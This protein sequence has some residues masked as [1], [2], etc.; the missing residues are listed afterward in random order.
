VKIPQLIAATGI[1]LISVVGLG[2]TAGAAPTASAC[3]SGAPS[4]VT[5]ENGVQ[6]Q[7]CVDSAAAA[8][9]VVPAAPSARASL[10]SEPTPTTSPSQLPKTGAGTGGLIIAAILVCS[11]CIASL[12]SRRK[13][14]SRRQP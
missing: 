8:P 13:D 2:G 4:V 12:L 11:G 14:L 6:H 5:D 1:A 7:A 3:V 9:P 10:L